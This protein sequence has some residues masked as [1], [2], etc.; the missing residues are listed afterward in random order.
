MKTSIWALFTSL[1]AGSFALA[2]S[3]PNSP[4]RITQFNRAG[5]L[6]WSNN[7]CPAT[8]VYEIQRA[9]SPTGAWQHHLY[10]T[11]QLTR[12][13]TNSL[14]SS[15][16]ATFYRLVLV[17]DAPMTFNYHFTDGFFCELAGQIRFGL[18]NSSSNYWNIGLVSDFCDGN[19]HPI[20]TGVLYGGLTKDGLGNFIVRL[21]FSPGAEGYVIEGHLHRGTVNGQCG[22]D[23]MSGTVYLSGFTQGESIGTFTATRVP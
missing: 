6:A 13:I 22:Y 5:A 14:S 12:Q 19:G 1:V 10:V 9:N 16:S 15:N 2:Q 17:S 8:P 11:N 18:F 20:G 3:T 21:R 7:L 23:S 4:L